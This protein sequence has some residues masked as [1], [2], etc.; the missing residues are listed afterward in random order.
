MSSKLVG[1]R[2]A[3]EAGA[4]E[5]VNLAE[6]PEDRGHDQGDTEQQ[7]HFAA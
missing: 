3:V 4:G 1:L 7:Q 5:P 6:A 2:C